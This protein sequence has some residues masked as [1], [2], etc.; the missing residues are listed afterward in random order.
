LRPRPV[1]NG[2]RQGSKMSH[3]ASV[4]SWRSIKISPA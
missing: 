3:W 4:N 2:G 1:F